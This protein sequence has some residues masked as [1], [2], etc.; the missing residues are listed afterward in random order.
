MSLIDEPFVALYALL[1]FILKK[2]LAATS[3]QIALLV[4][5]RP[6]VSVF[7]FYWSSN[8]TR[9]RSKL[10]SNLMGAWILARLPFFCFPIIDNVWYVIL[11]AA[12]YQLFSKASMP[13]LME[14]LKINV[15][16]KEKLIS[17]MYVINFIES[18]CFA[19]VF[20]ALLDMDTMA[21]K[22]LFFFAAFISVTSILVQMRISLPKFDQD[23]DE[24]KKTNKIIQ[25]WK[26][27]FSLLKERPDFAK[28]QIGFMIGGFGLM[29]MV[30]ARICYFADVLNLTHQSMANA[31]YIW[32]GLGVCVSSFLWRQA[33]ANQPVSRLMYYML[34]GFGVF[35]FTLIL[36]AYHSFFLYLSFLFYGIAQAGSH[37]LWNLS[38]VL[39]AKEEQS[40]RFS[41][42]NVHM[43]G[44]RGAIAPLLGGYLCSKIGEL[45][46]LVLAGSICFYGAYYVYRQMQEE[47][48]VLKISQG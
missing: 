41:T 38:G 27:S 22:Y 43:I 36:A 12:I 1:L 15:E 20:G 31:R 37:L 17:W 5:I 13:A 16:K 34:I 39:F 2:D 32:M 6:I 45:A 33:L 42:V 26:D 21:W 24:K 44:I 46:V 40:T 10:L 8:L 18:A 14:I 11:A 30:P 29:M 19:F 4:T 25:P 3:F 7:S 47:T 48:A 9:K 28:F 23:I 35:P